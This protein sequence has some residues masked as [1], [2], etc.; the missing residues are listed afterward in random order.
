[1]Q[2]KLTYY[3]SNLI[4][5]VVRAMSE[6]LQTKSNNEDIKP[7]CYVFKSQQSILSEDRADIALSWSQ[8]TLS[9]YI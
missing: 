6:N 4:N 9:S 8:Q 3:I 1:M 2:G 7:K 5:I